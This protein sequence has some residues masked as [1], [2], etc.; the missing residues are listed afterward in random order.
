MCYLED[1]K[2]KLY[3]VLSLK[4]ISDLFRAAKVNQKLCKGNEHHC[5]VLDLETAPGHTSKDG[6]E[7]V[8]SISFHRALSTLSED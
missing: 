6:R 2:T 5:V 4:E 7:Q 3:F 8:C 1:V